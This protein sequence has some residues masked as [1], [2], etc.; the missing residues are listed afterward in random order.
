ML[1]Y[2]EAAVLALDGHWPVEWPTRYDGRALR[3]MSK[4]RWLEYKAEYNAL[5]RSVRRPDSTEKS[6]K[7]TVDASC[8]Q[9]AISEAR[10]ADS[11]SVV[12]Q[13]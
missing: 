6:L 12:V 13:P 7:S 11:L 2:P 4:Q 3:V 8:V 9:S 1:R 10:D 5:Q